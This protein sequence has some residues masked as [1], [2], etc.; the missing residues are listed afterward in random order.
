M[1]F[2]DVALS[3]ESIS[4][5]FYIVDEKLNWRIVFRDCHTFN[6]FKAL[7]NV[8]LT[9]PKGKFIGILGRNGA[10]KSTLLRV[11][12]GVYQPS[13]GVINTTGDISGLFELGGLG[14]TRLTGEA[15]AHRFLEIYGV[16]KEE[17]KILVK[18]IQ[19]FSELENDFFKPIYS[20]STGMQARLFFAT[21]TEMQHKIYLVDELLSVGD[22]HFQAKCWKR[23][24]QRFSNGA[25]G[26]LVTHDWSS[27]I[28]LCQFSYI[29]DK[30]KVVENGRTDA[31]VRNY[32][33]LPMPTKEYAEII[34]TSTEGYTF[35]SNEDCTFKFD[36]LLKQTTRIAIAYTIELFKEGHSWQIMLMNDDFIPV[37]CQLG[38]N[39][40]VIKIKSLPLA[41][42]DYCFN[43]FLKSLDTNDFMQLDCKSW[44]YGNGIPLKVM[45]DS[46][47]ESVVLPWNVKIKEVEDATSKN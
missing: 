6:S 13:S 37:S 3:C 8:S 17:R 26:I 47:K 34:L 33:N 25:S 21:A 45:G 11:L 44:T 4:K 43:I 36:V 20:Y 18:N 29:L 16:K 41:A 30:G 12:S 23:L 22:E 38:I 5:E 2:E 32:L 9:V 1:I 28:K 24:N 39:H 27:V 46:R 7:E 19:D 15:Y 40:I 14:N 35:N 10:G 42:G 31:M